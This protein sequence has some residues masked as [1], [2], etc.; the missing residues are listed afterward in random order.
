MKKILFVCMGN[1]CRS[2]AAEGVMKSLVNQNGLKDK[3]FIDSAGTIDYHAG[4]LPDSRMIEAAAERGYELNHKARQITKSDL[5]KF[6]YIIT[7][8][9]Q[10]HRSVQRLDSQKKFQNKIFKMTD[11]L[12]EMKANEIPDPYYGDK[13]D[14][15]YSLDL[16]ED[17]AKG[18]LK[19]IKNEL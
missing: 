17:A 6:D 12:S 14:F 4:E 5:E 15:K 16:I 19:H 11:F 1:I 8:D 10:I 13:S 18:L 3:V 7:M 9:D 2:P